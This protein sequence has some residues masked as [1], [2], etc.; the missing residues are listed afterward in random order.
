MLEPAL[1][2]AARALTAVCVGAVLLV[3]VAGSAAHALPP[4]GAVVSAGAAPRLGTDAVGPLFTATRLHPGVVLTRCVE[5]TWSAGDASSIGLSV[6]AA[7]ALAP[8]LDVDVVVG[9]GG[10]YESCAGFVAE[11]PAWSG[12]LAALAASHGSPADQLALWSTTSADGVVGVRVQVTVHD[13][14]AAQALA[15]DAE[16]TFSLVPL[17]V[18]PGGGGS[19]PPPRPTA[20]PASPPAVPDLPVEPSSPGPTDEGPAQA[21]PSTG[22]Q[23]QPGPAPGVPAEGDGSGEGEDQPTG[24]PGSSGS[25]GPPSVTIP[26]TPTPSDPPSPWS[27]L[28]DDLAEAVASL[29]ESVAAVASQAGAPVAR[30]VRWTFWTLPLLLVFL[31]VQN[32][33]DRRDPKLAESPSYAVP[34]LPFDEG[35]DGPSR[36][37][38][39]AS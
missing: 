22:P 37:A 1:R 29:V 35:Y 30:G 9:S 2:R 5:L 16:L 20:P 12:S 26:M 10:G 28:A 11:R 36:I 32:R 27:V 15:A 4:G 33:I 38:E 19:E 18:A 7:G 23:A 6:V 24:G 13:D 14:D 3:P 39:E 34:S 25:S 21:G 17:T 31:L 8:Y